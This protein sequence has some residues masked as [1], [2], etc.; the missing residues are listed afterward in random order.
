MAPTPEAA[1]PAEQKPKKKL[2]LKTLLAVLSVLVLEGGTIL[3]FMLARGGPQVAHATDPIKG[4]SEETVQEMAEVP[5]AENFAVDNYTAGR[6]RVMVTMSVAAKVKKAQNDA[7]K[8]K[9]QEHKTEIMD[10]V[11]SLISSAPIDQIKDPRLQVLKR[12]IKAAVERIAGEGYVEE[13][14]V[15][16]WQTYAGE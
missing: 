13:I 2:P 5:L 10:A 11:R 7:F 1:T 3:V 4:V 16:L 12:E 9:V 6:T 15:P 8:A 14:L